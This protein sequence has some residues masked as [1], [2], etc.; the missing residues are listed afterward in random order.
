M[1]TAMPAVP[2][3][4]SGRRPVRSS[5][6]MATIVMPTLTAPLT[7]LA[8][9]EALLPKPAPL[10]QRRRVVDD[11]VD[12]GDLLEDREQRCR[13]ISAGRTLGLSS[14][15]D[16]GLLRWRQLFDLGDLGVDVVLGRAA[17][18]STSP[19][20]VLAALARPASA[21]SP[22]GTACRRTAG[23]RGS[24]RGRTSAAS[25]PRGQPVVDQVG[26]Q[27][28]RVIASWLK[29]TSAPRILR[30]GDLAD[31]ER[32]GHRRRADGEADHDPGDDQHPV[33][34]ARTRPSSTPTTNTTAVHEDRSGGGP[35]GRRP[36]RRP[37][38]RSRRRPAAGW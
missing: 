16:A 27:D 34:R 23:R 25:S 21:G 29:L 5:S 37:A 38:R 8:S 3:S 6:R 32:H 9:S 36:G 15:R 4:S 30:R 10:Q 14:S 31:V 24:R 17:G 1:P 2:V 13:P 18:C 22:S 11:R 33:G 7:T 35:T 20:L 19:R 26:H 12:T 28:A